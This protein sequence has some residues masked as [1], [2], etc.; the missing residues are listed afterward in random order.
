[1][2]TSDRVATAQLDRL[3]WLVA[4]PVPPSICRC[5]TRSM[6]HHVGPAPLP[7]PSGS[8]DAGGCESLPHIADEELL[9]D[10]SSFE[11]AGGVPGEACE[12]VCC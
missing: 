1:M 6:V 4:T 7:R 9:A 2:S 5:F 3:V 11:G 12:V 8:I 10:F